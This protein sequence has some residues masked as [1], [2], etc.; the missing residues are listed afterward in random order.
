M[1]VREKTFGNA[2]KDGLLQDKPE[3]DIIPESVVLGLHMKDLLI[4]IFTPSIL[5]SI[6]YIKVIF[7]SLLEDE[8]VISFSKNTRNT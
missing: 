2:A 8:G 4:Q 5:F 7:L 6:G 1:K 3:Q